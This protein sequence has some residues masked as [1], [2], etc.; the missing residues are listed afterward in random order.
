MNRFWLCSWRGF[1]WL[2]AWRGEVK[3]E[4]VAFSALLPCCRRAR[5]WLGRD[6]RYEPHACSGLQR[7]GP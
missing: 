6:N 2:K 5:A 4:I 1:A 7:P 3:M